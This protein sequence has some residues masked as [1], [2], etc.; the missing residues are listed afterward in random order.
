[1]LPLW[2][3]RLQIV[4]TPKHVSVARIRAGLKPRIVFKK[5]QSCEKPNQGEASWQPAIRLLRQ[6]LK[7]A[8]SAKANVEVIL[9]NH[10]VRYQLIKAQPDLGGL[11]EEKGFV[12]FSFAETYGN[13]S[14]QWSYRWGSG[15][16]IAS[17]VASAIDQAL[18]ESI[19][20]VLATTSFKLTSLQPYLMS[21]FNHIRK[22][23]DTKPILFVL[24][25]QGRA[26]VALLRDG[27]WV[28]LN[29]S[30]LGP[31]WSAE[32]S[33][34][35]ERELQKI[36]S[37]QEVENVLLCLPDY[38]DVKRLGNHSQSIRILTITPETLQD[39]KVLAIKPMEAKK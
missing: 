36:D 7:Q 17:Q 21:A 18:I 24:L 31:D 16:D 25:E 22:L 34:V 12:R 14:E 35:I 13:E 6:L 3:D 19:E 5:T 32:L 28:S 27:D 8:G 10:F 2:R 38:F 33:N 39:G 4:L 11:D 29:S 37:V 15:L 20:N 30:K 9:S 23:I 26:C 1:M